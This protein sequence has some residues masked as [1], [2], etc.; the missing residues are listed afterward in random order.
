MMSISS[1]KPHLLD[2]EGGC[3]Q[4]MMSVLFSQKKELLETVKK[5]NWVPDIIH[6]HGWM[7]GCDVTHIHETFYKKMR[8]CFQKLRLL[9]LYT[10]SPLMGL[11]V[12]MINKVKV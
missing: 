11:D 6:V 9:L 4:I 10:V 8:R 2:E 1:G 3:I 5:L 12:E 7:A